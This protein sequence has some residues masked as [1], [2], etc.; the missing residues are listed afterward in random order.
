MDTKN[1]HIICKLIKVS[2]LVQGVGFRPFIYRLAIE[3]QVY[4]WVNNRNDGVLIKAQAGAESLNSFIQDIKKKAPLASD[5]WSI[6]HDEVQPENFGNFSI[7]KSNNQS[8]EITEISP[9]I[10]VCPEC[11]SD[12]RNQP[13]RKNYPLINCTNCGPRFSIIHDLPYDRH[14]TTMKDF[15]MCETCH[16]EYV[17]VLDRRFHAQPVACNNC[18]PS[19]Q[20]LLNGQIINNLDE[21]IHTLDKLLKHGKII[22]IKGTGGYHL[23]CDA[24]NQ[25]AISKLREIKMRDA[26][27]FAVMFKNEELLSSYT[28]L[29]KIEKTEINSW[30]RPIVL[31]KSK[32]VLAAGVSNGFNTLGCMLPSMPFHYLLFE[33]IRQEVLVFTSGNISDEPIIISDAEALDKLGNK[34]DAIVSYNREIFNRNDDSVAFVANNV[35]RVLRR[36]RGFV[37]SPIRVAADVEGIFAAGAEL[38]NSFCI[39]RGKQAILSQHIGDLKNWET[40]LFYK[41]SFERFSRMFQFQ[42]RLIVADQHPDYLSTQFANELALKS[43]IPIIYVQH[44]HAHI[45]SC[46]AEHHLDEKVIGVAMDGTG[47]GTDGN[48]WGAEFF[49]CDYVD[50]ERVAHFGY[51][52][53]PGGD[54]VIMEPWRTAVAYLYKIYGAEFN[55]L[56]LPFLQKINKQ[57]LQLLIKSI[58]KGF[59]APLSCSAGRL[60]D[61][62]AAILGISVFSGF[63][64]EAPMRLENVIENNVVEPYPFSADNEVI[65]FEACIMEIVSDV[66][67]KVPI[68]N[69]SARFHN[70]IITAIF[71][72]TIQISQ[73]YGI[74]KVVFSGGSFQN[75][76][77]LEHLEHCF[78]KENDVEAYFPARVPANDGGIALGQLLIASKR[79]EMNLI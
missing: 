50:F 8:N 48:I 58:D 35:V 5:I 49:L 18:G 42:N 47:L 32:K 22:A 24:I 44:H 29:N 70:T 16:Q 62:V 20:M 43:S 75:R 53:L 36:S 39:G 10:A 59:N 7:R 61:A 34:V 28:E 37:P 45:A 66:L 63:H 13:H 4:G 33:N 2:G 52:P 51:Y 26:K 1:D 41:E 56:N 14:K 31:L 27:P 38:T 68:S 76:Y 74:N 12:L 23:V 3:H 64:A 60:F 11:L 78:E 30:K 67:A 79:R 9:D 54:K 19:Y 73:K 65:S 21:I 6:T 55:K 46:M 77:L 71:E 72:K 69:I 40:F 15:Q 17:N 25:Q 57:E